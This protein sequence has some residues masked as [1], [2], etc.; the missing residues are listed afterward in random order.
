KE[1]KP[2][3][4]HGDYDMMTQAVA[5]T[6]VDRHNNGCVFA[7]VDGHI[8]Y[9]TKQSIDPSFFVGSVLP[10]A[11][12]KPQ[13][14]GM[15]YR[16]LPGVYDHHPNNL[17]TVDIAADMAK[18]G[19][20]R[21][22]GTPSAE[23][24]TTARSGSITAMADNRTLLPAWLDQT[25]TVPS[26][27]IESTAYPYWNFKFG[28]NAFNFLQGITGT[29]SG[30]GTLDAS[31]RVFNLTLV[32]TGSG[33]K[34]IVVLAFRGQGEG[35]DGTV[36]INKITI[37]GVEY[38]LPSTTKLDLLDSVPNWNRCNFQAY[39]LILPV[40]QGKNIVLNIT[41]TRVLDTQP[42]NPYA[43]IGVALG[44]EE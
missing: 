3:I 12:E 20:T 42:A 34:R 29:E 35:N 26:T 30:G 4:V 18:F 41:A 44:F 33:V 39:G 27:E 36:T 28:P 17:S 14:I 13:T 40:T 24:S 31:P 21:V 5:A 32:P 43:T 37:G 25:L 1:N 11:L 2:Y 16:L 15:I 6:A 8:S 10:G 7:F 23:N 19:I 22:L 9:Q 38:V